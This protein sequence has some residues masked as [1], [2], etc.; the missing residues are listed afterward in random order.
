MKIKKI[1]LLICGATY[2]LVDPSHAAETAGAAENSV[3]V[4]GTV[5]IQSKARSDKVGDAVRET[6]PSSQTTLSKEQLEKFV[7]LDGAVTGALRYTPGVHF[8]GGDSSGLGP[9]PNKFRVTI[10]LI[11]GD[12]QIKQQASWFIGGQSRWRRR[13]SQVD[14]RHALQNDPALFNRA[15]GV[16]K[17]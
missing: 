10:D 4:L 16:C 7:G 14:G 2:S 17:L 12:A 6:E 11:E 9:D 15:A 5:V 1:A 3:D 13:N 8:G